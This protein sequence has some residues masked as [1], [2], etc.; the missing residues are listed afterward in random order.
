M[1]KKLKRWICK[2]LGGVDDGEVEVLKR[3]L[4]VREEA[5]FAL[6]ESNRRLEGELVDIS[7]LQK[8]IQSLKKRLLRLKATKGSRA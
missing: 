5:L 2:W 8:R 3:N 6:V 7:R 1:V 4:H